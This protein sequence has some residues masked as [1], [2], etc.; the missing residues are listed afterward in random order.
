MSCPLPLAAL[1]RAT[2]AFAFLGLSASALAQSNSGTPSQ[3]G[4]SARKDPGALKVLNLPD[5]GRWNRITSTAISPDGKWMTYTL[6]PNDGDATLFV[7]QLD[8]D[9]VYSANAGTAP[10]AGRGEGG[11]GF[12]GGAANGPAFSDDSRFVGYYLNP[13]AAKGRAR[14][15]PGGGRGGRGGAAPG[16]NTE[17]AARK[18]E[19]LDLESGTKFDVP[20]AASFKFA[21]GGH[22]LAVRTNKAPGDTTHD[23]ADLLLRELSSGASRNVGNVNQYDFDEN[24]RLFAYTLDAAEHLGNGVYL[25]DLASGETKMLDGASEIYDQLQWS[26]DG[27]NLAVLRGT[28]APDRKQRDNVVITWS[29]LGTPKLARVEY[30]PSKDAAFPK[31]M[32]LSEF[33]S[34][35]FSRDGSRVFVGIKEQDAEPAKAEEPQANVDVWHWKD[36][37]PQSVQ[38]IRIQQLRRATTPASIVLA[39]KRFVKLGSDDMPQVTPTANGTWAVGRDDSAYRGEVAWGG[40]HADYYRVNTQTGERTL[41]EKKIVR[42]MG[43]SP[44]SKW[45]LYLKDKHVKAVNL[46]TMKTVD[47]DDGEKLSFIDVDDDHPYELPTYGVAGWSKDGKYVLLNHKYDV[48]AVSLDGDKAIDLTQRVGTTQQIQFRVVRLDRRA[49]RGGRG[50]GGG[51]FG[52]GLGGEED[53]GID[54]TK[55][56]LLSAYGEF[57]KKT[58]YW[59]ASL[60]KAP[61]SLV[62]ADKQIG[63]AQKAEKADRVIFTEQTFKEFP[64]YWVATTAFASPRKVTDVNPQLSDYAWGS[65]VLIDYTNSKG[66]K[67]Q[68]TL[69]LPAGYQ[70]GKK[71]PML[72][73]FYEIMSNTHHTFSMPVYDDR[74]HI[75]TYASN[76]YLVLQPDVVYEIGKPGSS[77]VDCVESA[78]KKVIELGYA[79]PQHIGLQGHSWGGYQSSYILT[80]SKL[81]A[82]VVTGAPPTDLISFYDE[83]YPGTG[84]LQ[85]GIMELGQVRMGDGATPWTA[86]DLYEDQ[87]PIFHVRDIATPFLIL[88]GTADNAV[89]WHQGLEFYGAARRWGKHVILLSYPGE[90]HHLAKTENQKDFQIRM[91]QFFDHYLMDKPE[92]KWMSDGVP[93]V[94]KGAAIE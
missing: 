23:G 38:M 89:D 82:A 27:S 40:S 63:Q 45:F 77:A 37:D 18:F 28:K 57:T 73:Y 20:N 78:V 24:G 4:A 71:Y 51:I 35:R 60:G 44:D 56:V 67:L 43:T 16:A 9:K 94:K 72:V 1:R 15:G 25:I 47:L 49:G 91:K 58:G 32:I 22:W 92:P 62:W 6:Q 7:K 76:G 33:S 17:A 41:I 80:R 68:G 93:Q 65:K 90:P 36:P 55:P 59:T 14:G 11:G 54:L 19:L 42:T 53:E 12:G 70:P 66:K 74:P 2:L 46:E 3:Q 31:G 86:K 79:D 84:T 34:P 50:G 81:F 85:Q 21:K 5:Y 87:S 48:W 8:G 29:Q 83:T 69:T 13:P 39:T 75:S 88:H 26:T 52:A 10:A 30:D 64:D 61:M